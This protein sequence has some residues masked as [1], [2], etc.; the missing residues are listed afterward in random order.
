MVLYTQDGS[1]EVDYREVCM[2]LGLSSDLRNSEE[3]CQ[4]AFFIFDQV[5][6]I[7]TLHT[8]HGLPLHW[9]IADCVSVKDCSGT[10]SRQELTYLLQ[11]VRN[12][13]PDHAATQVTTAP[14]YAM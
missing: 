11:S 14:S 13:T 6:G 9:I 10:L 5:S 7:S 12:M 3:L 1:G 4:L 2:A 8:L